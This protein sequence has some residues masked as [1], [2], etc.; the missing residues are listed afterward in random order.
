ME[1]LECFEAFWNAHCLCVVP[2]RCFL[3]CRGLGFGAGVVGSGGH[4]GLS[5]GV[6]GSGGH[7][8]LGAGVVG[9]GGHRGLSVGVSCFFNGGVVGAEGFADG[10]SL[11][12]EFAH[13]FRGGFEQGCIFWPTTGEMIAR[14]CWSALPI[15]RGRAIASFEQGNNILAGNAPEVSREAD[16]AR[17]S[18]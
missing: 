9:S 16:G 18:G 6:I 7:R 2:F 17:S 11:G 10:P 13:N 1:S 3:I 12:I 15:F 4:R 14:S 5:A 8:G